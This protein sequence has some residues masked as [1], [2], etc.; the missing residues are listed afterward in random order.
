MSDY[1]NIYLPSY[2]SLPEEVFETIVDN[3]SVRIERIVSQ[4][5]KSPDD[6]WYN[7]AQNEWVLVI[8]GSAKIQFE[9]KVISLNKGDYLNIPAHVRHRV[10]KT[11]SNELT[12]W[13]AIFY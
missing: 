12:I 1:G 4:G 7:Q 6:F 8:Q 2:N 9:E 5:H 13:L 10:L 3:A 11:D